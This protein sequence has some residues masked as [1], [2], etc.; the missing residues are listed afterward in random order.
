MPELPEVETLKLS[1]QGNIT[2]STI[3]D[4]EIRRANLR[5]P[6]PVSLRSDV[7]G[8]K[9]LKLKRIAKYLVLELASGKGIII[10]LGMSGRFTLQTSSY[11]TKKHDHVIFHLDNDR[12]LVFNDARR[13]GLIE[14]SH[15]T[16]LEQHRFF[17]NLGLEPLSDEFSAEYLH[18]K[19]RAR[20]IP[21]KN[22]LM[23][24]NIVVGIGNI[25]ASESLFLAKVNPVRLCRTLSHEKI[26]DLTVS[27]K[28][29][30]T[31]AIEAGGT[32]LRDFVSGDNTPG[33][34][35]QKLFV[36]GREG[37]NCLVCDD[38]I[39]R[40][41]QSGRATFFCPTCQKL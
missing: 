3:I 16:E 39:L 6:I 18:K 12:Y 13:F 8:N 21:I 20:N 33:Y 41:K 35:K 38:I 22:S 19:L 7:A 24:N 15:L 23:D 25:Y 34:F 31:K 10:H 40:I 2:G 9:I 27:A 14:I 28:S 26:R 30:L 29:V 37:Q 1:L 36:Y 17:K 4:V 32:T 11:A 5:Y